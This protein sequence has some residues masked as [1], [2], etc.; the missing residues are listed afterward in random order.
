M[1]F[2]QDESHWHYFW[3]RPCDKLL[4]IAGREIFGRAVRRRVDGGWQYL[5]VDE[6][7]LSDQELLSA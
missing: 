1:I 3:P 4:S 2:F 5:N 6:D 7:K